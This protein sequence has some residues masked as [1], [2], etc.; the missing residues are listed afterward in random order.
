M[1]AAVGCKRSKPAFP[2]D[3]A[4]AAAPGHPPSDDSSENRTVRIPDQTRELVVAVVPD[5]DATTATL[6]HWRRAGAGWVADGTPWPAVIGHAGAA[7]GLGLHGDGA[8]E[9]RAGPVK[10]EGDGRSPAG[11][12]AIGPTFGYAAAAPTGA[13]VSYTPVTPTWRCVDD[14]ASSHY[15]GIFDEAGVVK[16]WTSA[17][18]L[19]RDD[20]LYRW[21]VEIRHNRAAVPEGGSCIFLHVWSGPR[22]TTIG[23]TAMAA[24]DLERL[25]AGLDPAARPL[26]VLLP[27]AELAALAGPWGV[28]Q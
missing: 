9:G 11:I 22:S 27:A 17:E 14:P 12:F 1:V 10:Q 19:R 21:V 15:T 18:D 2:A 20:D 8:P 16:D 13:H 25:I 4:G 6:T 5:W 24:P 7:W 28:P 23:C 26:F 3:A